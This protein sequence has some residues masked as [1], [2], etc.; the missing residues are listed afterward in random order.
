MLLLLFMAQ[1]PLVGQCLLIVE[2]S[3]SYSD[4]PHSVG[5]LWTSDQPDAETSTWQHTILTRDRHPCPS[6][7]FEPT[8]PASERSQTHALDRSVFHAVMF[9]S[10]S[11]SLWIPYSTSC[12]KEGN[13]KHVFCYVAMYV[14]YLEYRYTVYTITRIA[15]VTTLKISV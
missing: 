15:N 3:R 7:G 12:L 4:T 14:C 8:T 11:L 2:A 10:S 9:F 1:Q 13:Y 5:L 6:A